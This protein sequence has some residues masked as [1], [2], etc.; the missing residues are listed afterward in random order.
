MAASAVGNIY[1][2]LNVDTTGAR[3]FNAVAGSVSRGSAQMR[4]SL[5]ATEKAAERLRHTMS[6]GW[7]SRIF[8]D[9]I[10]QAASANNEV[11]RLRATMMALSAVTG[12]SVTGAFAATFLLQTADASN[13]LNNQLRTVTDSEENLI[14]VR[15]RLYDVSQESRADLAS[16]V[17]LYARVSRAAEE[18]GKSQED[19][20]RV[21][22]T[23]QKAFAIGGAS[24]AEASGAAIQLSQGIASDRFSG[25]EYRSVSENAPVLLQEMARYLGVTIGQMRQLAYDGEL[26]GKVVT[27]AIL[28]ASKAIDAGFNKTIPTVSQSLTR[29][30][31]AFLQ[32]IGEVDTQYGVTRKLSEAL[33]NLAENFDEVAKYAGYAAAAVGAIFLA[34]AGASG[35]SNVATGLAGLYLG[36]GGSDSKATLATLKA[37]R[38]EIVRTLAALKSSAGA[39]VKNGVLSFTGTDVGAI[40]AYNNGL[41][42]LAANSAQAA[43][44]QTK[45]SAST[46]AMAVASRIGGGILGML[47]GWTGAALLAVIA[48]IG[49]YQVGVQAAAE[50]TD[51]LKKELAD[52]GYVSKDFAGNMERVGKSLEELTIDELR[53]KLSELRE[54]MTRMTE[55]RP[56]WERLFGNTDDTNLQENAEKLTS[57]ID[58]LKLQQS[59][60]FAGLGST[61]GFSQAD[62]PFL[63]TLDELTGK[64]RE[65]EMTAAEYRAEW[66]RLSPTFSGVSA[67]AS[68]LAINLS[69]SVELLEAAAKRTKDVEKELSDISKTGPDAGWVDQIIAQEKAL[70]TASRSTSILGEAFSG[71]VDAARLADSE[72][73]ILDVMADLRKEAEAIAEA[74]GETINLNGTELRQR[75]EAVVKEQ[76]LADATKRI[77]DLRD[78]LNADGLTLV[79]Q[80]AAA[81]VNELFDQL[82]TGNVDVETMRTRMDEIS[83]LRLSDTMDGLLEKII[84]AIPEL[85]TLLGLAQSFPGVGADSIGGGASWDTLSQYKDDLA[86]QEKVGGGVVSDALK[87]AGLSERDAYIIDKAKELIDDAKSA[88]GSLSQ[89]AAEG[90]AAKLYDLEQRTK[91]TKKATDDAADAAKKYAEGMADLNRQVATST[92]DSFEQDVLS[93]AQGLGISTEEIDAFIAA[94]NSGGMDAAPEKFQQIA[95]ALRQ[96]NAN[97]TLSDLN[98]EFEQL[99]RSDEDQQIAETLRDIGVAADSALGV[100]ITQKTKL[101]NLVSSI[102]DAV[103]EISSSFYSDL[104]SDLEDGESFWDALANAASNALDTISDKIVEFLASQA[105]NQLL[106]ALGGTSSGSSSNIFSTILSALF[107]TSS[108]SSGGLNVNGDALFADGGKVSGAGSGTSDSIPAYL[109]NG[110]YVVNAAATKKFLP[111]LNSIN[112]G[113]ALPKFRYGGVAGF[114]EGGL[115]AANVNGSAATAPVNVNVHNNNGSD[116]EVRQ[117]GASLEVI[118]DKAVARAGAKPGSKTYKML[119]AVHGTRTQLTQR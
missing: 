16:T 83:K 95:D 5:G 41:N 12:T 57:I 38:E 1:I 23:V 64:V 75:A 37:Q 45:L 88:G 4:T 21:A 98:F 89:G 47:G 99:F 26:T 76:D 44:A 119:K 110:E 107:G 51:R 19:L 70:A 71:E 52:L 42:Q 96:I 114:S 108:S 3:A 10:R 20:I 72:K 40:A 54:E 11:A 43:A 118:I 17:T 69:N 112:F 74:R 86:A 103:K 61:A 25:E 32:N 59:V 81:S 66:E 97:Q 36:Q 50:R 79:D 116:V 113:D 111:L 13:R 84:A 82:Q 18:F 8:N 39:R 34:R 22:Q 101:I 117:K 100:L 92:F 29:L 58:T 9:V 33:S 28:G 80:K 49:S 6:Q 30:N 53:V 24:Q 31:N 105:F 62:L 7:R 63:E 115:A 65:G 55:G 109:S 48:A 93:T 94:V 104:K 102:K 91:D 27:D 15:Q 85:A 67:N 2:G 46:R 87:Y 77:A 106:E 14:A 60:P 56:F 35:I 78:S 73:R 90:A 68:T